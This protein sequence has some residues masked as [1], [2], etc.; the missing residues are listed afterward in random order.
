MG[1]FR[2][3]LVHKILE[4][5]VPM[6]DIP[7]VQ[8]AQGQQH[9]LHSPRRVRL[10]VTTNI[11]QPVE[12]L[13]ARAIL[14][15]KMNKILLL[16]HVEQATDIGMIQ[17]EKN[18][19]LVSHHVQ[20]ARVLPTDLHRLQRVGLTVVLAHAQLH[21]PSQ[22]AAEHLALHVVVDVQAPG[23]VKSPPGLADPGERVDQRGRGRPSRSSL[24]MGSCHWHTL[25]GVETTRLLVPASVHRRGVLHVDDIVALCGGP[26][27]GRGRLIHTGPGAGLGEARQVAHVLL[28]H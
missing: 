19:G 8:V 15:H 13:L 18:P 25:A 22:A 23:H 21:G 28:W 24:V 11:M 7:P 26:A 14:H 5:H 4:L 27:L 12:Q 20:L 16:V 9:L 1:R 17:P 3:I 10:R 2:R 6:G